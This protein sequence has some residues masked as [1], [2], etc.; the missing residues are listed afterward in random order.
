M[1]TTSCIPTAAR[2]ARAM[3]RI[4][5]SPS[6]GSNVLGRSSVNG[7]NRLPAP[8]ASTMP[9]MNCDRSFGLLALLLEGRRALPGLVPHPA[10]D[11]LGDERPPQH[12]SRH[13][14]GRPR[15]V[16]HTDAPHVDEPHRP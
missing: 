11:T 5:V 14:Q 9:I 4:V 10:D 1:M 2:L 6:T 13:E 15:D 7:F 3:S 12:G 16:G 8:A